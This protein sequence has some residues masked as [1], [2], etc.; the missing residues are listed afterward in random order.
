MKKIMIAVAALL[1]LS[2]AARAEGRITKQVDSSCSFSTSEGRVQARF[3]VQYLVFD[4]DRGREEIQVK[5]TLV[6]DGARIAAEHP[7]CMW[8]R[9]GGTFCAHANYELR[10]QIGSGDKVERASLVRWSGVDLLALGEGSCQ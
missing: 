9:A 4:E 8:R 2:G 5:S 10:P 1:A 6:L 3:S 7:S